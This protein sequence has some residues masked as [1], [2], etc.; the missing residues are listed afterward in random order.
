MQLAAGTKLDVYEILGPLGAG[1]MG[2]VYRARDLSL[3]REV[4]IKILPAYV[5]QEPDRLRRFEQ[6][7]QATAA[8]N[9]PN[10]LAVHQFGTF[11]GAPY[12][13]SELLVGDT[14]REA[15][16]RGPLS[17]RKT[18]DYGVQIA[19]GLAAAHDKG[20][21]HRD[22]KPENLFITKDGRIKILDFGLAKLK[23][24]PNSSEGADGPAPTQTKQTEPGV[25]MGTVGYMSPE[26]VRG[27]TVDHRT[28]I[29]A[30]GA[31]LY[32]MLAGKRAFQRPTSAE[33]MTAILNEDPAGISQVAQ[34][35]PPGLQ[36][37]V[38]RCLE[39]NPEQ[40]FQSASDLAFALEALSDSG[41]ASVTAIDQPPRSRWVWPAA[42]AGVV[43]LAA[44]G[45]AWW[46]I[47]PPVPV[48]ESVTQLTDDGEPKPGDIGIYTDGSRIYF[49]EGAVG[50]RRIAE[51]SV[52][53]G[54]TALVDAKLDSPQILGLAADGSTML[55][56]TGSDESFAR[57]LWSI[58][59]PAGDPRRIRA[60]EATGA[61][62][63][64]DGRIVFTSGQEVF[65]ADKDGANQRKL[66]SLPGVPFMP[67]V[68]P[69]GQTISIVMAQTAIPSLVEIAANGTEL[70]TASSAVTGGGVWSS[71]GRYLL[72]PDSSS[73]VW[74]L[75]VQ[76]GLLH[77]LK[78]P[79]RL[80]AGP[81]LYTSVCPSRD[82]KKLFALAAK[83]RGELMR[84]DSKSRQFVP[85]LSGIS[86]VEPTFSRDGKW[87]AYASYPD[88]NLWRSRSDGSDQLQLTY[89]PMK[90]NV[91]RIS[92]DGMKVTF[93]SDAQTFVVDMSGGSPPE[94][95]AKGNFNVGPVWSP[96]GKQLVV[97]SAKEGDNIGDKNSL[98]L[99]IVDLRSGKISAV[100]SPEGMVGGWWVTQ[101]TLV[102][103]TQDF[104]K[105]MTFD[106]KTQ[107]WT[108]L[109][110]GPLTA[111]AVSP[112]GQYIYYSTGG[113]E[114]KAW[115]LRFAD[116]K[117]EMITSLI[118]PTGMG[119]MGW[120]Q[121]IDVAPDGSAIF[122]RET[123]T[124]EVYALNVRWP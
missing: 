77:R 98:G 4:A 91:P 55:A 76:T 45:I 111:W 37:V 44:A 79:T 121:A 63:F 25:V 56:T 38:H 2:E 67:R 34:N 54:S 108:E 60:I 78:Q 32:E 107:R 88:G 30:F 24:Q 11:D 7:A 73:D 21:V 69:D 117:I 106:L 29:F 118:D 6:E 26:Q 100:P 23:Q 18:I 82:G 17:V 85:F 33:T 90:V 71:D 59:L 89:P 92:P 112:D 36:R 105:L 95:V 102:A 22:L 50:S 8:L 14:L 9:H 19:H 97:E 43:A 119:K 115:R 46:R 93:Y 109:T 61:A 15:L 27:K 42:A 83:Q 5:S 72:Y 40:R 51:V 80:T 113:A 110:A 20:I 68:S 12:L 58:P 10:I 99:R 16:D 123:G 66:A 120:V 104:T 13:A 39:K 86:A 96:D 52:N 75:P 70:R 116:L 64:P 35:T 122:T 65:A 84:Y 74:A 114:P 53:G 81:L 28:D 124:Q 41:S 87:V 57:P 48:V 94:R 49:N 3:K 47:P 31:I 62:Y 101:D 103:A 1:G